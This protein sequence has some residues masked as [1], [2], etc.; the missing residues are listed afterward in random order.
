L[1]HCKIKRPWAVNPQKFGIEVRPCRHIPDRNVMRLARK[2]L[3]GTRPSSL[4]RAI[5]MDL[6]HFPEGPTRI[7]ARNMNHG[8]STRDAF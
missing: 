8:G 7:T 6:Q 4:R 3:D 5:V 1:L 2:P